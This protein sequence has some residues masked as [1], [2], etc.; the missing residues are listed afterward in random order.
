MIL[1][2]ENTFK[3]ICTFNVKGTDSNSY[4][5]PQIEILLWVEQENACFT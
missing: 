3:D 1:Q 2:I 5:V 4:R